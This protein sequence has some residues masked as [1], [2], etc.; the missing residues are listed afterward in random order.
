[1]SPSALAS[2][3]GVTALVGAVK[4][5]VGLGGQMTKMVSHF[6]QTQVGL[7]TVLQDAEK[8]K[9]LFEDLRKFSFDTTF[10]VDELAEASTQLLYA[11][12]STKDL[13]KNLKMLGDLAGG[14]KGKFAELTDIFAKINTTGKATSM[15]L[16][17]I[18]MRGIPIQKTLKEIGKTGTAS[19]RDITEAFEYLTGETGQFHDA[20]G[21]IIDTFE[22]KEGFIADTFKEIQVNLADASGLTDMYKSSLDV[23]YNALAWINDL[24]AKI[25]KNPVYK[26]LFQGAIVTMLVALGT[27]IVTSVIP[28]LISVATQLGI[29][30]TLKAIIN[31]TTL[32]AGLAVGSVVAGI[33]MMTSSQNEFS[34]S[35]AQATEK[36]QKEIDKLKELLETQKSDTSDK[37]SRG[38]IVETQE[39]LLMKQIEEAKIIRDNFLKNNEGHELD[40]I[41]TYELEKLESNIAKYEAQLEKMKNS[42]F[43]AVGI[44]EKKQAQYIENTIKQLETSYKNA[45]DDIANKWQDMD[46][47]KLEN[48]EEELKKYQEIKALIDSGRSSAVEVTTGTG[49]KQLQYS[50]AF[51]DE[52]VRKT[53]K[54][55]SQ[56]EKEIKDA[57]IKNWKDDFES[58]VSDYQSYVLNQIGVNI[59]TE[60][61]KVS[62]GKESQYFDKEGKFKGVGTYDLLSNAN[63]NTF[64]K[65]NTVSGMA[66]LLGVTQSSSI[67]MQSDNLQKAISSLVQY[68]DIAK[69]D[70][71]KGRWKKGELMVNQEVLKTYLD[72]MD[73]LT[74]DYYTKQYEEIKNVGDLRTKLLAEELGMT[75]EQYEATKKARE[76]SQ[77]LKDIALAKT[78]SEYSEAIGGHAGTALKGV[79]SAISGTD[80][81][82]LVNNL[83][84]SDKSK[85]DALIDTIITIVAN[86]IGGME[87]ITLILNPLTNAL[88][89]LEPLIK[90]VMLVIYGVVRVLQP[91]FK[92]IMNFLN[93]I[94]GG[95]FD[96]LADSWDE[97]V[98][99][100]KNETS[101]L[102]KL[103]EQY[104]NLHD[105]MV[106]QEEYYLSMKQQ[107]NSD[108]YRDSMYKVNDMILTSSGKFSTH[109]EDTIIAMKHPEDL[110]K[111]GGVVMIKPVINNNMSDS[112]DVNVQQRTNAEG[113]SE[114]I[115]TISKKIAGDVA[116]GINGWDNALAT[117]QSRLQGLSRI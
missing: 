109:P 40:S 70:D 31:P 38:D 37:T 87:G 48:L 60:L 6:E 117:R 28:A 76:E 5:L 108:A 93:W 36:I 24:L 54:I 45:Q 51:S 20:M 14:N 68:A 107:I 85:K 98:T 101:T 44:A 96:R 88:K 71:E 15:Q 63:K 30:A 29:I 62:D 35:T 103:N 111:S 55:L 19:A 8:G 79:D 22:G 49:S 74:V 102:Q 104:K 67:K 43:N 66:D 25:N 61:K 106:E 16:Q 115:V 110:M 64:A 50:N 2:V 75:V 86:L 92:F 100:Q 84:D 73:K 82:I 65:F 9:Q 99:A 13:N 47:A 12:M 105:A 114:M 10:G 1:M 32:L 53:N 90:T 7:G 41:G 94:T 89:E 27:A 81:G 83:M 78:L 56:I 52:E 80:V 39:Q 91:L 34:Q 58:V 23:L 46:S 21:N 72:E 59:D 57:K 112:A 77:K 18:A 3:A 33:S 26:A 42:M 69:E 97:L 116:R 11:G 95:L 17:Q 4:G 113:M